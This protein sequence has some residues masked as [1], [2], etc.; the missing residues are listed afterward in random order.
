VGIYRQLLEQSSQMTEMSVQVARSRMGVES[1]EARV[2]KLEKAVETRIAKLEKMAS[3][4][5]R[6]LGAVLG[7]LI[8]AFALLTILVVRLIH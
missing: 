1:V 8:M 7:L 3:I 4:A 2:A 5:V 6:L